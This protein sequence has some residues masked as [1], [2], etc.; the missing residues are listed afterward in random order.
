MRYTIK[1]IHY[2]SVLILKIYSKKNP[3]EC[4]KVSI[5]FYKILDKR[6]MTFDKIPEYSEDLCAVIDIATDIVRG[7]V[8]DEKI[9][10]HLSKKEKSDILLF[11]EKFCKNEF[12]NEFVNGQVKV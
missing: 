10:K 5:S 4:I 11:I 3:K 2:V 8:F 6:L 7:V 12:I 9:K 1:Q